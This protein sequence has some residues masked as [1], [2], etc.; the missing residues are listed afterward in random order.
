MPLTKSIVKRIA[1]QT[2]CVT[3]QPFNNNYQFV[4]MKEMMAFAKAMYDLGAKDAKDKEVK[5]EA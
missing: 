5:N 3:P 2:S 4:G 1:T